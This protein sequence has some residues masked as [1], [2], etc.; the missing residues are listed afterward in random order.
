MPG[1]HARLPPKLLA[2][3]GLVERSN[4]YAKKSQFKT[5]ISNREVENT[6][7]CQ[8]TSGREGAT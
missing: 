6:T 4:V 1:R 8:Q 5:L 7:R 3:F 2:N